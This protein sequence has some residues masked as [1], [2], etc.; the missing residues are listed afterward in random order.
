MK[1]LVES[2]RYRDA[3]NLFDLQSPSVTDKTLTLALKA[4]ANLRDR[5]RGIRIH[6]QLSP[7]LLQDP[8]I[9]TSLM[10]FYSKRPLSA[11]VSLPQLNAR[12]PPHGQRLNL[13]Y[14]NQ[15]SPSLS[16][17]A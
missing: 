10:H 3:L 12:K 8:F 5:E 15:G 17:V 6:S 13:S 9:Q 1:Q 11:I 4:C 7:H 14:E 16:Y 2:R